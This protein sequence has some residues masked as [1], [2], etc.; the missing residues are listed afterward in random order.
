MDCAKYSKVALKR[1]PA[2]SQTMSC[3]LLHGVSFA[4]SGVHVLMQKADAVVASIAKLG[5]ILGVEPQVAQSLVT[6]DPRY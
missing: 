3:S 1:R 4:E 5:Q 6:T 2:H